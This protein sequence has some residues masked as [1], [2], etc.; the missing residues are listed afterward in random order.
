MLNYPK[1][2]KKPIRE[3]A[4]S[5][6]EM[7][8]FLNGTEENPYHYLWLI[9]F[10]TGFRRG[11]LL[12]LKWA[13]VNFDSCKIRLHRQVVIENNKRVVKDQLKTAGSSATVVVLPLVLSAL[14]SYKIKNSELLLKFGVKIQDSDFIFRDIEGN[15]FRPDV[16]SHNFSK[17]VK[18]LGL[19]AELTMHSTRHTFATLCADINIDSKKLQAFMRHDDIKTTMHYVG[20]MSDKGFTSEAE[21]INS[22]FSD[23]LTNTI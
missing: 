15:P 7:V 6:D 3:K 5:A 16:I 2:K 11:E 22:A 17:A 20:T 21:K 10:L 18:K 9:A 19:R 8:L 4:F 13:D 1:I 14:E 12:G 23:I